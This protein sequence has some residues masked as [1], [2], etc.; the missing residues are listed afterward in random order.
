MFQRYE[1]VIDYDQ[2]LRLPPPL[3][4]ISY[5]IMMLEWMFRR[6][7]KFNYHFLRRKVITDENSSD[8]VDGGATVTVVGGG[9]GSENGGGVAVEKGD[10]PYK[11][12]RKMSESNTLASKKQ[13]DHSLY[14][15]VIVQDYAKNMDES[16][17]EKDLNKEQAI[18]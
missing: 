15:K 9:G 8:A 17:R 11:I 16:A 2:R 18:R 13:I 6:N 1:I 5:I 4:I 7:S 10:D 3:N 14:W 12:L